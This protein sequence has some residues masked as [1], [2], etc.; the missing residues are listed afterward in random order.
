[1]GLFKD[2]ITHQNMALPTTL[3]VKESTERVSIT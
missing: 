2:Q 3:S 1:M